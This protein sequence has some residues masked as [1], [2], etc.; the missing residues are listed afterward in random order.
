MVLRM[1]SVTQT[2]WIGVRHASSGKPTGWEVGVRQTSFYNLDRQIRAK[3]HSGILFGYLRQRV[4][5]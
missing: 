3:L 1:L 5:D 2:G 4:G